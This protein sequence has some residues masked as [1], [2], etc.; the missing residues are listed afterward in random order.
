MPEIKASLELLDLRRF[1]AEDGR[2]L[3]DVPRGP[4]PDP[5]TP[6]PVRFLP[7]WDNVLLS[8]KDRT[9]VLSEAYRKRIIGM[10]GDVAPTFLVDGFVAGIWRIENERV[11]VQ[12]FAP[13]SRAQQR[14]VRDEAERLEAFLR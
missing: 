1:R 6:A 14:E 8:F 12:P 3:L 11:V 5:R 2:E 9:R 13:L 4:L 10:N 7:K